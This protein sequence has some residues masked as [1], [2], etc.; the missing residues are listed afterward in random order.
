[1][2]DENNLPIPYQPLTGLAARLGRK[3]QARRM[4]YCSRFIIETACNADLFSRGQHDMQE[5]AK[6]HAAQDKT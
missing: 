1:M 5:Q 6:D 3:L 4:P 2:N